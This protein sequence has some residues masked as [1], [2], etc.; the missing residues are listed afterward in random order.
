MGVPCSARTWLERNARP[1]N[2]RWF[3]CLE[4][5]VNGHIASEPLGRSFVGGL[6]T[7]PCNIHRLSFLGPWTSLVN[8]VPPRSFREPHS[9]LRYDHVH[10]NVIR[11]RVNRQKRLL[12]I[13]HAQFEWRVFHRGERQSKKPP[14]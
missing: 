13:A 11:L 2:T 6:R 10:R 12:S 9:L 7:T 5:R 3:G 14:P 1:T 8:T 4:Q